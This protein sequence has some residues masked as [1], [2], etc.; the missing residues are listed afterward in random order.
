[1][2]MTW[3]KRRQVCL[4]SFILL[5]VRRSITLSHTHTHPQ[6][7]TH[8]ASS[9]WGREWD[10]T[11]SITRCPDKMKVEMRCTERVPHNKPEVLCVFVCS[12]VVC[13]TARGEN[14]EETASC[15]LCKGFHVPI[16]WFPAMYYLS[17]PPSSSSTLSIFLPFLPFYHLADVPCHNSPVLPSFVSLW[18]WTGVADWCCWKRN[19][20]W[21]DVVCLVG[22]QMCCGEHH[23]T[24]WNNCCV[25]QLKPMN[26]FKIRKT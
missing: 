17:V 26:I 22:N 14:E 21:L 13:Q 12:A 8:P 6:A 16:R 2:L 20:Y 9:L 11:H 3:Q 23:I 18:A 5:A 19:R 7:C 15:L 24:P 4:D 1:M 10:A 25:R